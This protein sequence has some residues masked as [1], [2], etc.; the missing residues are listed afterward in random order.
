VVVPTP[1]PNR[2]FIFKPW[3]RIT[4]AL[5]HGAFFVGAWCPGKN[6]WYDSISKLYI[7]RI[8]FFP[9]SL[10]SAF[11]STRNY[12]TEDGHRHCFYLG[13][14]TVNI[15]LFLKSVPFHPVRVVGILV[16]CLFVCW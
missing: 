1:S 10:V 13:H 11:K 8:L 12:K 14:I 6:L 7:F 4:Q 2:D 5:L 3:G 15:F 9:E 16:S